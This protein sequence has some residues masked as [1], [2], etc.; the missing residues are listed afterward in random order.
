[1]VCLWGSDTLRLANPGDFRVDIERAIKGGVSDP[2][3]ETLMKMLALVGIGERAGSGLPKIFG[4]WEES[5]Y[6]TPFY[7]EEFGP[8][9]TVL[10]LP[11]KEKSDRDEG[12]STAGNTVEKRSNEEVERNA[13][14]P[15]R[16]RSWNTS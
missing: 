5:G 8:D 3:H 14:K 1:M 2:R 16:K 15:A 7:E 10:T 13:T 12:D 9:R 6:P 4:G 11:L